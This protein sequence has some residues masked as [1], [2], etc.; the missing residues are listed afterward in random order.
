MLR[1]HDLHNTSLKFDAEREFVITTNAQLVPATKVFLGSK[2]STGFFDQVNICCN[3]AL[4]VDN[5][6]VISEV[7]ILGAT[8]TDEMK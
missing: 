8:Y 1:I 4:R 5:L 3:D 7:N 2:R 6:D